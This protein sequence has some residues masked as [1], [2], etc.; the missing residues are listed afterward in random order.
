MFNL[1]GF[2]LRMTVLRQLTLLVT[3]VSCL[4]PLHAASLPYGSEIEVRLLHKIGSRSSHV[5]DHVQA[6][7][8]TPVFDGNRVLLPAGTPVSGTVDHI[9]RLGLG[10]RHV[11]ARLDL[12]FTE[13][14]LS[15]ASTIPIDARVSSVETARESVRTDGAVIGINP[16]AN[17]STGISALFTLCNLAERELRIPIVAF[18]LLAARSPDAEITF[19]AGTEML[20]RT[21]RGIELKVPEL[22]EAS[23]P[24]LSAARISE[25]QDKLAALPEQQ[26]NRGPNHPSDL[27][28]VM[29]LG[30]E[31]QISRAFHAAG[32]GAPES[33]GLL[34]F[35]H[36]F[37][38]AVE[39]KSYNRL[40]MSNLKLNGS[41]PDA[42]FEKGLNTFAKRHHVRLWEDGPSGA[43]LGAATEDVSY[44][45]Y[46]A[47][48]THATDRNIDNERAK[49]INDLAFTGCVEKGSLIPRASLTPERE[50]GS[51]ILTDGD[52]AVIQLNSC[53]NPKGMPTDPQKARPVRVIRAAIAVGVDLARSNPVSVGVALTASLLDSGKMRANQRI[54]AARL[55]ARPSAVASATRQPPDGSLAAR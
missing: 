52:I 30:S 49:I 25:V 31:E 32:W 5:G 48:L 26:T 15:D 6:V 10:L 51:S 19:S 17:F 54:Q 4:T 38:C 27:V 12:H 46:R 11:N 14:H 43:W 2:Y 29:I 35:Y 42:S 24:E 3:A 39:R 16:T 45:M 22:Q 44:K 1:Y 8:I 28:N 36:M 18:K 50:F 23:I 21:N 53:M 40:P 33:H 55:Y 7:I 9:D 20:L 41:S 47:H 13:L 34:A 37:H